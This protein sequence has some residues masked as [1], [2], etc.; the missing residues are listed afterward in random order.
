[1]AGL[2]SYIYTDGRSNPPDYVV[3]IGSERVQAMLTED[4][5]IEIVSGH[6][7]VGLKVKPV[8][9]PAPEPVTE[10]APKGDT[11][12]GWPDGYK[13]TRHGAYVAVLSPQGEVVASDSP[14]GKYKGENA[15]QEAAW[16][17]K[18]ATQ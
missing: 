18:E 1:M 14:S 7:F 2:V 3:T 6:E 16:K 10:T 12:D 11:R 4:A 9:K 15:A 8:P 13:H 17:H 5:P